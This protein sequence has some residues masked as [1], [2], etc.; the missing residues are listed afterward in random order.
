MIIEERLNSLAK[1]LS[2]HLFRVVEEFVDSRPRHGKLQILHLLD[3]YQGL[4]APHIKN[5]NSSEL[6]KAFV[7]IRSHLCQNNTRWVVGHKL[8]ELYNLIKLLA[9]KGVIT[10]ELIFPDKPKSDTEHKAYKDQRIPAALISKIKSKK[11]SADEEFEETLSRTCSPEIAH[12]LKEHVYCFKQVKHHRKPLDSYLNYASSENPRWYEHPKVIEGT[13]LNFRNNLLKTLSRNTAYQNFQNVKNSLAVLRDHNL[14]SRETDFPDNLRRCAKTSKV[15]LNNPLLCS[16]DIYDEREKNLFR[17]TPNFI[18]ELSEDIDNN[19]K[20]LLKEAKK[21]VF[22]GYQKF[23]EQENII[24]KS[25]VE[26]FLKH[27]N[28]LILKEV[29]RKGQKSW[30]MECNPFSSKVHSNTMR[31]NNLVAYFDHFYECFISGVSKHDLS[32]LHFSKEVQQYLGLTTQVASAMQVII[33]EELGINP[34]S[35]YRAHVFSDGH[36]HEFIQVTDEGSV[37]LRVLKPRARHCKTRKAVGLLDDPIETKQQNI[38]AATC[39][40]MAL[41]MTNRARKFTNQKEL[42]LCATRDG[43]G[44]PTPSTFQNEFKKIR[45][46]AGKESK[47]LKEATL[48][49][50]RSS[51]GVWIYLDSNGN[52][53]KTANYFGNTVTTTLTRY[54]PDYLT[55]LVYRVKIRTFQNILLFM[56]VSRDES[57]ADSLGLTAENFRNQV[58]KAFDNPEMGGSLYESL[59]SQGPDY[60]ISET[61]YF[62]VSLKNIMLALRYA[63]EGENQTLR[64]DCIAVISKISEG[65]IIMKQLLRQAQKKLNSNEES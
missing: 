42:W 64:H 16:T 47:V 6:T 33:V 9:N 44:N 27:P 63:K 51:K 13:L 32:G 58:G 48:K 34:Y 14:I 8:Y 49:K 41:E 62:C 55:E 36:E 24:S 2:P 56:A 11:K 37:R 45:V 50:I 7:Y 38:D 28:L 60:N 21:L 15:R 59:K 22:D 40:K 20:L 61:K 31:Q 10:K 26:E 43:V 65:P 57:P 1:T 46:K 39:L 12:R 25:E 53:L 17:N 4:L 18:K 5:N 30:S 3:T 52:S 23:K 35:L 19:L 54:I 29:T